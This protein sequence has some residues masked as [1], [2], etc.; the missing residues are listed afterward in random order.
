MSTEDDQIKKLNALLKLFGTGYGVSRA[1]HDQEPNSM[2]LSYETGDGWGFIFE[3]WDET[4]YFE[5]IEQLTAA[6][7]TEIEKK[8]E[9]R[10]EPLTPEKDNLEPFMERIIKTLT[11]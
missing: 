9:S 3:R 8:T 6:V 4:D 10:A 5:T 1:P 7:H 11:K 2:Q